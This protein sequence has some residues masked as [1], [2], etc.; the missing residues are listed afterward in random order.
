VCWQF[1]RTTLARSLN[2]SHEPEQL[3]TIPVGVQAV[4]AH[5]THPAGLACLFETDAVRS[6]LRLIENER[7]SDLVLKVDI[8]APGASTIDVA[9]RGGR[10]RSECEAATIG[11][12]DTLTNY[13]HCESAGVVVIVSRQCS[14]TCIWC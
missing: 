5:P 14:G 9:K 3:F 13:R 2:V 1:G 10:R 8:A 6:M 12:H 4:D 11:E 7:A